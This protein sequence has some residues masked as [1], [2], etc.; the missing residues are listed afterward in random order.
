MFDNRS[1]C[2][3]PIWE[4]KLRVIKNSLVNQRILEE[5]NCEILL[6]QYFLSSGFCNKLHLVAFLVRR[7]W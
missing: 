4:N 5:R 2:N 6:S 7:F 3:K 1:L